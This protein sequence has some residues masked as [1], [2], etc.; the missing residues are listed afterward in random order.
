MDK[1]T[2]VDHDTW[3]REGIFR[4][5]TEQWT[6][7]WF[8]CSLQLDV[9][10]LVHRQKA[11]GEK[12]V[13][14]LMYAITR[15]LSQHPNFCMQLKDGKLGYYD[16]IHPLYPV[17]RPTGNF[18]FHSLRYR[19]DFR[20]FYE[21]YLEESV[22]NKEAKGAF[23]ETPLENYYILSNIPYMTFDGFSFSM[24]NA[25]GYYSPT[26]ST[27]RYREE[28]GRLLLPFAATVNHATVDAYHVHLLAAG[29]QKLFQ[30]SEEWNS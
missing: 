6:T 8:S 3:D 29:I 17:L 20:E 14:A 22:R 18:T 27:G 2:W 24:K 9:T 15:E 7:T 23:A 30:T 16:V 5:Y 21:A 1:F 13:P 25:K 19:E 28:G 10:E 12:F 26:I 4:L 11:R